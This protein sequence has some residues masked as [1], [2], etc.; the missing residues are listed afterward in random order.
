[1]QGQAVPEAGRGW[2]LSTPPLDEAVESFAQGEMLSLSKGKLRGAKLQAQSLKFE[3]WA[4][5][6]KA[7]SWQALQA[8]L[9]SFLAGSSLSKGP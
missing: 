5:D 2:C 4:L 3:V 6:S 1:M 8:Q 7:L 9:S